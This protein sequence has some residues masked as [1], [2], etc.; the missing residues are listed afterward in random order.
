MNENWD[1]QCALDRKLLADIHMA[2]CGDTTL[3]VPGLVQIVGRHDTDISMLKQ[4]R[5]NG[6]LLGRVGNYIVAGAVSI[7]FIGCFVIAVYEMIR[8]GK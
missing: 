3:G 4:T 6:M 5:N 2:V 1:K 7:S 8:G